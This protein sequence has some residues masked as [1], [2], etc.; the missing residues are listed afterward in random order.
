[1]LTTP[2]SETAGANSV[3]LLQSL[4]TGWAAG[5]HSHTEPAA[6]LLAHRA[7]HRPERDQEVQGSCARPSATKPPG[8]QRRGRPSHAHTWR[9]GGPHSILRLP[10]IL[11]GKGQHPREQRGPGGRPAL[12]GRAP[13]GLSHDVGLGKESASLPN[14]LN[15]CK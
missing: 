15:K 2:S 4:C 9:G 14:A 5:P 10:P 7:S 12:P 13:S 11:Q 6:S 3:F 1:M 8:P